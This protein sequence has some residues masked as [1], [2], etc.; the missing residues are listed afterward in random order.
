V[1]DDTTDL[2]HGTTPRDLDKQCMNC[3]VEKVVMRGTD[4]MTGILMYVGL[5]CEYL[6]RHAL[7]IAPVE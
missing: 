5:R 6:I 2:N 3:G 4:P 7:D 1:P